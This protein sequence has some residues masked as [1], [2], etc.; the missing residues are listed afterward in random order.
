MVEEGQGVV[1]GWRV[2]ARAVERRPR[3]QARRHGLHDWVNSGWLQD[4]RGKSLHE[5]DVELE[6][7]AWADEVEGN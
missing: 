7:P 3:R 1:V 5:D 6:E 4:E 2:R